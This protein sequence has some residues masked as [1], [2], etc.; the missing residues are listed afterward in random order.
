MSPELEQRLYDG[1]PRL[2]RERHNPEMPLGKWG[3]E[4]GDECFDL[5]WELSQQL[6]AYIQANPEFADCRATQIKEKIGSLRYHIWPR[7]EATCAM[8]ERIRER[9]EAIIQSASQSERE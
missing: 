6:T 4:C 3:M 8:V 9:S 1:F 2:F 5:I 7:N